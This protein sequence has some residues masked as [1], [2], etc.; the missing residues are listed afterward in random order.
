L[1]G[2]VLG[3]VVTLLVIWLGVYVYFSQGMAPVGTAAEAMPFEKKL[4][5]MALHARVEKEMPQTVPIQPNETVYVAGAHDYVEHCA[6]CHGV[7]GKP[8]TAI[9]KG[10]FPKPPN[11]FQGKGVTDDSPNESYWKIAHGIRLTGMPAFD[12]SLSETQ[13]WQIALLIANA[14]KLPAS[15]TQLLSGAP[16]TTTPA[17]APSTP[18]TSTKR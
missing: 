12:K 13:M 15:A 6:V 4:A 14:D 7:P 3:I 9:A 10:M 2:F 18:A 5:R 16:E 1:K 17:V 11:L 8:Q